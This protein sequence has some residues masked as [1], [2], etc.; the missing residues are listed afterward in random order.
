MV[1]RRS[2]ANGRGYY[3]IQMIK[4]PEINAFGVKT[5]VYLYEFAR[6][7]KTHLHYKCMNRECRC[8]MK[9]FYN[10]RDNKNIQNI[11]INGNTHS[12]PSQKVN[13]YIPI[14][15]ESIKKAAVNIVD[16]QGIFLHV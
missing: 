9:I 14:N 12:H 11:V 5:E 6:L 4:K 13:N 7:Y 2:H 10:G 16:I 1:V 15:N 8:T 3:S